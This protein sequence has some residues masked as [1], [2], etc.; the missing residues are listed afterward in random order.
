ME[1]VTSFI[2]NN[3]IFAVF[4]LPWIKLQDTYIS[5][6]NINKIFFI[7]FFEKCCWTLFKWNSFINIEILN[8]LGVRKNSIL[9]W[10]QCIF[11]FK[12][13][14]ISIIQIFFIYVDNFFH[15]LHVLINSLLLLFHVGLLKTLTRG[16]FLNFLSFLW[17]HFHR[18]LLFMC[19]VLYRLYLYWYRMTNK[20]EK[21]LK[22][23]SYNKDKNK[24][25]TD[26]LY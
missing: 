24:L 14:K 25:L 23:Y 4:N 18:L 16:S 19:I 3:F 17:Y 6:P 2:S 22:G 8:L 15:S 9:L 21:I 20:Y 5:Y 10:I 7:S 11:T 12:T 1:L 13:F 26:Y